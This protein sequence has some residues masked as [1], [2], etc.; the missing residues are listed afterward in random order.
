M[1][2]REGRRRP[3]GERGNS[4]GEATAGKVM[5]NGDGWKGVSRKGPAPSRVAGG[6]IAGARGRKKY[7]QFSKNCAYAHYTAHSANANIAGRPASCQRI[8]ATANAHCVMAY[9][10][11]RM[12]YGVWCIAHGACASHVTHDASRMARG[13]S[14]IAHGA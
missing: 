2:A 7:A 8:P 13:V 6:W 11:W 3:A 1:K 5:R 10:A 4:R 14:C 12:A 9:G